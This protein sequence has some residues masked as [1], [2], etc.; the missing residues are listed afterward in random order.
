[1][2]KNRQIMQIK[3]E[4]SWLIFKSKQPKQL[5]SQVQQNS[6]ETREAGASVIFPH[7]VKSQQ[8]LRSYVSLI[9]TD[10]VVN[11]TAESSCR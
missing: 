11:G 4:Y 1:M 2:D 6:G 3:R 7:D 9:Q 10:C 8:S 5:V